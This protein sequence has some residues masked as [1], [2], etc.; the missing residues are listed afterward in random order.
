[1]PLLLSS[2]EGALG[3]GKVISDN[4]NKC[5]EYHVKYHSTNNCIDV[6]LNKVYITSD[7]YQRLY[8]LVSNALPE[9]CVLAIITPKDGSTLKTGYIKD[10]EDLI[11]LTKNAGIPCN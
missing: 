10:L 5:N 3:V 9:Q 2:C 4:N 7:E 1:M 11:K 8:N 6:A